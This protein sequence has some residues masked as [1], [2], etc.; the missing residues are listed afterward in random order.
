MSECARLR[1]K[2]RDGL[3]AVVSHM[4]GYLSI[5]QAFP[6]PEDTDVETFRKRVRDYLRACVEIDLPEGLL[7][8]RMT[9]GV[10]V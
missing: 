4:Q 3:V 8:R 9:E 1:D 5:S 2:E 6:R 7:K 10:S